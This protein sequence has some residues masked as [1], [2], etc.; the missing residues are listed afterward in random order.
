[1]LRKAQEGG[2][3]PKQRFQVTATSSN[4]DAQQRTCLQL[5]PREMDP[6]ERKRGRGREKSRAQRRKRTVPD[7]TH[8]Q[9]GRKNAGRKEARTTAWYGIKANRLLTLLDKDAGRV[10]RLDEDV[11]GRVAVERLLEPLLVN[12]VTNEPDRT[13]Q[14]EETVEGTELSWCHAKSR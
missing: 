7:E 9:V 5:T 10:E 3:H 6:T 11:V 12:E 8:A 14:N 4:C 2:G 1:M 13:T